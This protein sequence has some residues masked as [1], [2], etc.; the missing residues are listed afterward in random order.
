MRNAVSKGPPLTYFRI[1]GDI[2]IYIYIY[3]YYDFIFS[4]LVESHMIRN[5]FKKVKKRKKLFEVKKNKFF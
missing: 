5:K 4:L 1:A 3:I 2:Y